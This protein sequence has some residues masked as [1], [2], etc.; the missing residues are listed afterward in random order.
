MPNFNTSFNP[1]ESLPAPAGESVEPKYGY[2]QDEYGNRVIGV[3]GSIDVVAMHQEHL[4][5][6][7]LTSIIN[8]ATYGD[9]DAMKKIQGWAN[10][11][12]LDGTALPTDVLSAQS[13]INAGEEA[14]GELPLELRREYGFDKLKFLHSYTLQA[15]D[16][17]SFS[18]VVKKLYP[19]TVTEPINK[20]VKSNE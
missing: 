7:L 5:D 1:G 19:D 11:D 15:D 2:T 12:Y 6:T 8:R 16:P 9:V 3:I 4:Q 10:S 17:N 20:E 14:F 18:S 13:M